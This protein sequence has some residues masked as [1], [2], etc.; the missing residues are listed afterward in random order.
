MNM[1]NASVKN[2]N[3]S[4]C[5]HGVL[6]HFAKERLFWR[7]ACQGIDTGGPW[8]PGFPFCGVYDNSMRTETDEAFSVAGPQ[9]ASRGIPCLENNFTVISFIF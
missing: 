9:P 3:F 7:M 2:R 5:F 8:F 4:P 1:R 6:V